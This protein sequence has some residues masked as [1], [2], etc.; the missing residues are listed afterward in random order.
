MAKINS[1]STP[2]KKNYKKPL[3]VG[4]LLLIGLCGIMAA[5]ELS[6]TTYIFH[7]KPVAVSASET[8]KG[9]TVGTQ[10][11]SNKATNSTDAGVPNNSVGQDK[12]PT[13]SSSNTTG[14]LVEPTG[15]F[16]SNHRPSAAANQTLASSCTTTP[17]ASCQI[18]FTNGGTTISLPAQTT[19]VGGSTF[20]NWK[21]SDYGIGQGTWAIRATATLNGQS[22]SAVD[23]TNMVVAP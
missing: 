2:N 22:V 6:N 21:L 3:L 14:T 7:K 1:T 4:L 16:V 9:E 23:A 5:L 8:T 12:N 18:V 19:D 10:S 15:N 20:W 13:N 11:S 17:G